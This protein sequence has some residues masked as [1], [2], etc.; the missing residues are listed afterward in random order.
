[1]NIERTSQIMAQDRMTQHRRKGKWINQRQY[2]SCSTLMQERAS[3]YL[4]GGVEVF[5]TSMESS[6]HSMSCPFH[7]GTKVTTT[8]GLKMS[9]YGKLLANTVRATI[10]ITTGAGGFSI[11][12]CLKLHARVSKFSPAFELLYPDMLHRRFMSTGLSQT[13]ELCNYFESALQ[14][15]YELFQDKVASPTDVDQDGYTLI[16]VVQTPVLR[17]LHTDHCD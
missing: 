9:Y 7:I 16:T 10:S 12:P 14:Q 1:M 13:N 17:R 4:I 8:V 6:K 5:K 15:L 3:T 2:C 11:N